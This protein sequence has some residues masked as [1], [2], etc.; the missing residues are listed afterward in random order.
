MGR[1]KISV[2]TTRLNQVAITGLG[3]LAPGGMGIEAFWDSLVH[4]RS[5]V[6]RITLFDASDCAAQTAGE[7]A[8]FNP[9]EFIRPQAKPARMP[10]QTQLSLAAVQMALKDSG[11]QPG[12]QDWPAQ[13]SLVVG[14]A[15]PA[16]DLIEKAYMRFHRRGASGL[17]PGLIGHAQ[18]HSIAGQ[19]N[20]YFGFFDR[21]QTT[22]SACPSGLDALGIA[23]AMV[24][25]GEA[26]VV[27]AGGADAPLSKVYFNALVN[28]GLVS[29]RSGDPAKISAPF[30]A[31]CDTGV[32]SEGAG[33]LVLENAALARA[34]GA[35]IYA[36]CTGYGQAIDP[37]LEAIESGL[38]TA[39]KAALNMA[40]LRPE[41]VDYICAH[42][43]GHPEL[44][45]AEVA[46][47]H[48]VFGDWAYRLPVSSIKGVT[49]NTMCAAGSHQTAAAAKA[50]YHG[51]VPP[52]AN[53]VHPAMGCDLDFVPGQ[54]RRTDVHHALINN[55]GV[56]GGNSCLIVERF[57]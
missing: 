53:L 38:S 7:V 5:G 14:S 12:T 21:F 37:D 18:S 52:T 34:R 20:Q 19:I 35:R 1:S 32:V 30:D 36:S 29:I 23:A 51:L 46:C 26:D 27:L 28:A 48:E 2:Q 44:D 39:I 25:R 8:G 57:E 3:V 56:G 43:P 31:S 50:I 41:D 10:R 54:A 42:G 49:G 4:A 22:A 15:S 6:R 40:G 9:T 55:H 47:I 11:G 13:I 17:S 24:A 33:F 16:E 45:R